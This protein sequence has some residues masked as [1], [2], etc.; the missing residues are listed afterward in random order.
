LLLPAKFDASL[1]SIDGMTFYNNSLVAIQ[2][3]VTPMRSTI[4]RL[5][6]NQNELVSYQVIDRAHPSFN[7]PTI[8]CIADDTFYYVG[9][10]LWSGYTK[11]R[12]LKPENE[13]QDV[14]ILKCDL[15]KLRL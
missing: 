8:G 6:E 4:Y 7:E 1:K 14:V 9:N 3:L 12:K 2:N 5:N 15:K 13:L 10:S 11:E